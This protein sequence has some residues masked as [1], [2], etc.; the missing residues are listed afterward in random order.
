[1][2]PVQDLAALFRHLCL[3]FERDPDGKGAARLLGDYARSGSDWH[4]YAHGSAAGYTR[5]LVEATADFELL[6]LCW[7]PGQKSPVHDHQG[8]NCWMACLA[9]T[10]DEVQYAFP[11][12]PASPLRRGATRRCRPGDVAFIRDQIGLHDVGNV[13]AEP[14][15][16]LHLYSKPFAAC[17]VFDEA[18]GQVS[19]RQLGYHSVRGVLQT[20]ALRGRAP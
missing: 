11:T 10:I 14:A 17:R 16:S 5:N 2:T 12:G 15:A 3:E 4:P 6:L 18:T 20:A 7:G 8:Q 9:G 1:M 19:L 13:G